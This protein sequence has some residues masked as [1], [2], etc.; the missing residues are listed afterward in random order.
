MGFAD[1]T[2]D[3]PD[4][5]AEAA[6]AAANIPACFGELLVSSA[7]RRVVL[8]SRSRTI[9]SCPVF[10]KYRAH[11]CIRTRGCALVMVGESGKF[12][13]ELGQL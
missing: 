7:L 10:T 1:L 4:I 5:A 12:I 6:V 3:A 9:T 8:L 13:L 11:L 2:L